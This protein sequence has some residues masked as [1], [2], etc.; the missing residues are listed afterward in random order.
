MTGQEASRDCSIGDSLPWLYS[1]LRPRLILPLMR[2]MYFP[3][4]I[5]AMWLAAHEFHIAQ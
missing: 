4:H 2:R 1:V 5:R 3:D